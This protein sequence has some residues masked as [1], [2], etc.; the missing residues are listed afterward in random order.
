MIQLRTGGLKMKLIWHY[1]PW[2]YLPAMVKS[3]ALRG[4]SA[5]AAGEA[6]MLWFSANQQWEP[7]AT[8]M[9][10]KNSGQV[11]QMT[12]K[13][14]VAQ[15]GCIRFG[16]AADDY[17][18]LNWKDACAAAGTPRES[19]RVLEKVGKK[20]GAGPAHWFATAATIPLAELNFQVWLDGWKDAT[21]PQ[22]M[23]GALRVVA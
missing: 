8:K 11:V 21:S 10:K 14:Q 16:I 17:R 13:Q 12:F 3:G 19:R 23:A 20:A 6:L 2:A 7:N 4:S 18:L 1:A 22:D 9:L 15:F 5:G